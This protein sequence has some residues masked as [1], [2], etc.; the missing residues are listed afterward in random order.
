MST[1]SVPERIAEYLGNPELM[2]PARVRD[3]LIAC[4]EEIERLQSVSVVEA[5]REYVR[6]CTELNARQP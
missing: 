3:L 6:I 5:M 2:E 1:G 4:R